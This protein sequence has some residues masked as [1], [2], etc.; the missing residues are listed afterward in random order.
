MRLPRYIPRAWH[1]V[2]LIFLLAACQPISNYDTEA[3]P[4]IGA[5]ATTTSTNSPNLRLV[6]WNIQ[7]GEDADAAAM[8]LL[9]NENLSGADVLLLQEM[10]ETAVSQIAESLQYNYIYYRV[11]SHSVILQK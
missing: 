4:F 7:Y 3:T 1:F 10:D 8:A 9:E 6:T 2:F 5:Y 11:H